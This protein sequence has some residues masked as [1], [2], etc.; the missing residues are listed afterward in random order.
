M[1]KGTGGL[2]NKIQNILITQYLPIVLSAF[3]SLAIFYYPL[4]SAI[5]LV[6]LSPLLS[7]LA[8]RLSL[9][10]VAT[11]IIVFFATQKPFSDIAEYM[12]IYNGIYNGSIEVFN[13]PRFGKGLE[14]MFL[15]FMKF[16]GYITDA[17]GQALLLA[18]YCLIVALLTSI[19]KDIDDKFRVMLLGLFFLNLGFIEVTS[20]FLRQIISTL[21]F[22]YAI[23]PTTRCRWVLFL[24]SFFFHI[25]AAINIIIY[26]A[27]LLTRKQKVSLPIVIVFSF[28]G[29]SFL[30]LS[31]LF[32]FILQQFSDVS[33]NDKFSTLPV[34]YIIITTV[35]LLIICRLR[36]LSGNKERLTSFLLIK[37][38]V[39]F[40]TLLPFP[41]LSNRLGMILFALYPFFLKNYLF[42][43]GMKFKQKYFYGCL[44]LAI[45]LLPFLYLMLNV[46]AGNNSYTFL[47]SR[48]LNENV[49]NII[50]YLT[51]TFSNGLEYINQG[52][53]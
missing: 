22:L 17:N 4:L 45:N 37:E 53:K 47:E 21:I 10:F 1:F 14:F 16:V 12:S 29:A 2:N 9:T 18:S 39:L 40:Y 13:Y 15:A 3:F 25:S 11:V 46:T 28:L 26:I 8:R 50:S 32:D 20:Y 36:F 7:S 52:N 48:P 6:F 51:H 49:Y 34:N 42:N 35:N 33:S 19:T 5:I 31:P 24:V 30:F 38:V 23:K 41:A 27:Y 44:L 43:S